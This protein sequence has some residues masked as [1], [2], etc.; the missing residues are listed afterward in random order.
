MVSYGLEFFS[1]VNCGCCGGSSGGSSGSSGTRHEV[2]GLGRVSNG[3]LQANVTNAAAGT[4]VTLTAVPDPGFVLT[5]LTIRDALGANIPVSKLSDGRYRFTMPST[6]IT[7]KAVFSPAQFPFLDVPAG[8]WYREAVDYVYQN[9]M[10]NGVSESAFDPNGTTTR[11]Q[12]V[13]IL[14]RLESEPAADNGGV[15]LT[16]IPAGKWYTAAV[17]W[18][19]STGIVDGYGDGRFGPNDQIT[20]EQLA[21]ILYRYCKFK[22]R[23]LTAV[24][25]LSVFQDAGKVSSW[26]K[27]AMAWANGSG[28]IT[29][30]SETTLDPKGSATR[31]EAATVLMRFHS[32]LTKS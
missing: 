32:S 2:G 26:A 12:I 7:L 18:A 5:S 16:D 15:P 8:K 24:G 23:D 19:A 29:G 11:A 17:R 20:R 28:L 27:D 21:V 4:A 14:H 9:G 3:V 6:A 10:M 22:G 13:T 30:K 31:A 25:D 1:V